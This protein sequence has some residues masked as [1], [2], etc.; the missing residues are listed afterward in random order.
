[1]VEAVVAQSVVEP[2]VVPRPR[3]GAASPVT[4]SVVIP[5]LDEAHGID[6]L[7]L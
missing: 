1:M 7:S 6:R 2:S 4:L 5:M 3:V